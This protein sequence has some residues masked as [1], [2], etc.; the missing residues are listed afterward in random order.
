VLY[1]NQNES[2]NERN[3]R[4]NLNVKKSGNKEETEDEII[5]LR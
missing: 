3:D 5:D 1:G 4:V 2:F